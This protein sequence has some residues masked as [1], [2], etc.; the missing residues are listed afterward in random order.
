MR[1]RL[2]QSVALKEYFAQVHPGMHVI[3]INAQRHLKRSNR[4][5]ELPILFQGNSQLVVSVGGIWPNRQRLAKS[6]DRLLALP[7]GFKRHPQMTVRRRKIG[8]QKNRA[9]QE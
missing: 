1:N 6:L 2:I 7:G 8:L 4:R 3:R 5:I 9:A